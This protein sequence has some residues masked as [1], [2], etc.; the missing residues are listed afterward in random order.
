MSSLPFTTTLLDGSPRCQ[1]LTKAGTQC[2]RRAEVGSIYCWQ[3]QDYVPGSVTVKTRQAT[4]KTPRVTAAIVTTPVIPILE[5]KVPAGSYVRTETITTEIK[6]DTKM[7]S[8]NKLAG[9]VWGHGPFIIN[10]EIGYNSGNFVPIEFSENRDYTLKEITDRI[11]DLYK[12]ALT[13]EA[14]ELILEETGYNKELFQDLLAEQQT[15]VKVRNADTMGSKI[16]I[17]SFYGSGGE[18]EVNLGS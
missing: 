6:I 4:V 2:T 8:T 1:A 17:E 11:V 12:I 15:G 9:V 10:A 18:Y 7:R 5:Q 3:H 16:F 14:L 13:K